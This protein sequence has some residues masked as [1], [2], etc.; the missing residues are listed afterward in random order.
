MRVGFIGLGMMGKGMAANLQKAGHQLI[1]HDLN[2]AAAEPFLANGATWASSPRQVAEASEVIFTSLPVPA[3]VEAVA[4]GPNG[5]IEGMKP[6]TA[7]FDMS[8]NSVAVVR[9][10]NAAF[11]EK[12]LYMLDS[13]VSG[14]PGGA[15]SGKM[16]IWV[17]GD[18]QQFNRHK[19]VL[20]AM[21]DQARY[22]GPIGAGTIAKLVHNCTSAVVGVALAEV[23]TMGI[24]AG[25]EP[26]ELWEAVRQ[27]ATGRQRTFDRLGKF[28]SS[29]YD[30]ADFALRL[31]HKDVS[32]AVGLGREVGPA[33]RVVAGDGV[34]FPLNQ[35][36]VMPKIAAPVQRFLVQRGD[37]RIEGARFQV[38]RA[39]IPPAIEIGQEQRRRPRLDHPVLDPVWK[40]YAHA[41]GRVG[42]TATR[43]GSARP[44]RLPVGSAA[45]G[46]AD[47]H[48][49]LGVAL[50]DLLGGFGVHD[51]V[52]HT[53][54]PHAARVL[55]LDR[56]CRGAADRSTLPAQETDHAADGSAIEA[57]LRCRHL[58]GFEN[59]ELDYP[60]RGLE[61]A[62][63]KHFA[64]LIRIAQ[65]VG[66][67]EF[68]EQWAEIGALEHLEVRLG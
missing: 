42:R 29:S 9:K 1:V 48:L 34:L 23:M 38:R 64:R 17:G 33:V 3:D 2:R 19:T 53:D 25:V 4:L 50:R 51:L 46:G 41:I 27:G 30:P 65:V 24:K 67:G 7:F 60:F 21:G 28:L 55:G 57:F 47:L 26:L 10:I 20:D 18:E 52:A 5:L 35:A 14:G 59:V 36:S 15:A 13:P 68:V 37:Q 40:M 44:T 58:L 49:F 56:A 6:D 22:I 32:L 11:A 61:F 39:G 63:A 62:A 31:L 45:R 12:N 43:M 16:A 66:Q 8:T 54:Y